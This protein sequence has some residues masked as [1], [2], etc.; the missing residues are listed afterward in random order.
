MLI[1]L[2]LYCCIYGLGFSETNSGKLTQQQVRK[3]S[4]VG[5][6]P[7]NYMRN[8]WMMGNFHLVRNRSSI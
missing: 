2:M 4:D 7:F 1:L 5:E 3:D 8:F 6:K